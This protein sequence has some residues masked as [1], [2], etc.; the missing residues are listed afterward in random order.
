MSGSRWNEHPLAPNLLFALLQL[1]LGKVRSAAE[2]LEQRCKRVVIGA[3]L[4]GIM[5]RLTG[6][7]LCALLRLF[8]A[9]GTVGVDLL[10]GAASCEGGRESWQQS[11][12]AEGSVSG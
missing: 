9:H 6:I 8:G 10:A 11:H 1:P 2:L 5:A 3:H 12:E 4:V 7:A